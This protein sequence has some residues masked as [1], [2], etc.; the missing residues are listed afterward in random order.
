[1]I[2]PQADA[3]DNVIYIWMPVGV[4]QF[5]HTSLRL[6]NGEYVSWWPQGRKAKCGFLQKRNKCNCSLQ[7]DITEEGM[8][9]DYIF[10]IPS[11]QLDIAKMSTYWNKHKTTGH[12]SL[13][14]QNCS[15]VVYHVLRAGG[16]PMSL[17]I[18]WRPETLRRYLTIYLGGGSGFQIYLNMPTWDISYKEKIILYTWKAQ[19]GTERHHSLL[20]DYSVYVSWWPGTSSTAHAASNLAEDRRQIGRNED[21]SYTF[22]ANEMEYYLMRRRWKQM[23]GEDRSQMWGVSSEWVIK[24]ILLAG[25]ASPFRVAGTLIMQKVF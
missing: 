25:G 23:M 13:L 8:D 6:S 24:Q 1:M 14:D 10:N 4:S 21:K 19:G 17:T 11:T 16:A 22:P 3:G 20:L 2:R 15:W 12:Y 5:G 18:L 7:D 9:P